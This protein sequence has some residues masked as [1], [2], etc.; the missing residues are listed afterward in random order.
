MRHSG[1]ASRRRGTLTLGG[2]LLAALLLGLWGLSDTQARSADEE[3]AASSSAAAP[4]TART[5]RRAAPPA[6]GPFALALPP[7]EAGAA[8]PDDP[9]LP[10]QTRELWQRRLARARHTLDS[11]RESTRYPPESRPMSEHPDQVH[12]AAPEREVPVRTPTGEDSGLRLR[13]RQSRVFVAGEESVDFSVACED[14]RGSP[15]R[16]EVL[17]AQA[18]EPPYLAGAGALS[19]VPLAFAPAGEGSWAARFQPARQG[20]ALFSGQLTVAVQVRAAGLET[21]AGF[22]ILY[23]RSPP[24]TFTGRVRDVLEGGSLHFLVGLQV[25][26]AGR[27]VLA[28]RVDDASGQPFAYLSFNEELPAGAQE[29]RL[30]VFGKL[31]RD[32]QPRQPLRL[33]D[34]EGFL[35]LEEGDPDRELLGAQLGPV[36]TARSYPPA[37]FS[38]AEWQSEERQRH[39]DEFSRDVKRA[40]EGLAAAPP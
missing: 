8:P 4:P 29:V 23:T 19:P 36:H 31:L 6:D 14:A 24:A 9:D 33:R 15:Q 40:E 7:D 20:F 17:G 16:C 28:G 38:D 39:L 35:L 27:Y 1:P 21:S 30:T 32:A 11:Y 10:P 18:S 2:L 25:R 3:R 37:S 13:L 22:D 12:P 34:L 5:P 26:K